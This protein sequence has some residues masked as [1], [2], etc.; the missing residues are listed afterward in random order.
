MQAGQASAYFWFEL[1]SQLGCKDAVS[2]NWVVLLSSGRPQFKGWDQWYLRP[3]G[4]LELRG[5]KELSRVWRPTSWVGLS[6]CPCL[7]LVDF[8]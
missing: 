2:S 8:I 1:V 3:N 6:D 7:Y 5:N 4:G